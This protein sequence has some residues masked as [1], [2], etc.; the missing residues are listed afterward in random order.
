LIP[1]V[2]WIV[3]QL[4]KFVLQASRVGVDFRKLYESGGMPSAHSA[5]ITSS[6]ATIGI[7]EGFR[8]PLFGLALVMSIIIIYDALGVR[9]STG[10]HAVAIRELYGMQGKDKVLKEQAIGKTHGHTLPEVIG[11]SIVGVV[12]ALLLTFERSIARIDSTLDRTSAS[13]FWLWFGVIATTLM[14]T[15]LAG[16]HYRRE[17]SSATTPP[18]EKTTRR[19]PKRRHSKSRR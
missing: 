5:L 17:S 18:R 16:R 3:A 15:G 19:P 1:L 11:G 9:H 13:V 2:A 4:L 7:L 14:L 8:S 6:A 12:L 10:L